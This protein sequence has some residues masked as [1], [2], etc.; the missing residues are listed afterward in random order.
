MVK[1]RRRRHDRLLAAPPV[2]CR[3]LFVQPVSPAQKKRMGKTTASPRK[4]KAGLPPQTAP[5]PQMQ[6]PMQP[7]QLVR[8]PQMPQQ[9]MMHQ[10]IPPQM[11]TVYQQPQVVPVYHT[12]VMQQ[13]HVVQLPQQMTQQV[14]TQQVPQQMHQGQPPRGVQ[15]VPVSHSLP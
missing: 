12:P 10:P 2:Q 13:M 6:V 4:V 14:P 8:P 7:Q 15:Q 9:P 1:C 11:H 5:Q 3:R